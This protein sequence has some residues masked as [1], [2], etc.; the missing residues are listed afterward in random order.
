MLFFPHLA[1]AQYK[2][3]DF[4]LKSLDTT[5]SFKK[6]VEKTSQEVE[7]PLEINERISG[8]SISGSLKLGNNEDSYLRILMRDYNDND[9]LVY[10]CYPLLLNSK[11]AL[12]DNIGIETIELMNVRPKSL[13]VELNNSSLQIEYIHYQKE[14]MNKEQIAISREKLRKRQCDYIASMLN[15]HLKERGMTW[16]AGATSISLSTFEEKKDMFGGKVPQMYGFEYYI[17]G[18]FVMPNNNEEAK[19]IK[20]N[21]QY[22]DEWD[23]RNRHGKNWMTSVKRQQPCATCWAF[24]ALG[25]LEAYTNLYYNRLYN[26]DLSEQELLACM[27]NTCHSGGNTGAALSYV[28][29]NG[30]VEEECFPYSGSDND[31][32]SNKCQ[33]PSEKIWISNHYS[34]SNSL[35]ENAIKKRLLKAPLAFGISPWWHAIVLAGYKTIALGERIYIKTSSQDEWVTAD[36]SL[37]G[38]TAWLIKNSWG[39]TWGDNGYAY[40]VTNQSDLYLMY[41]LSGNITSMIHSDSDVLCED[42][43]GD[44]YYFWG[45][46]D[47]PSHC[48]SWVPDEPDGDD[49]DI[50]YGP[51][52]EYGN[53]EQLTCG[54]TINNLTTYTGNQTLSCR[55][56]IVNGGVLTIT[57]ST[58]MSGNAKIRVCEGGTLIVDGGIIQCAKLI[59]V[60]G[61]TIILKNGGIIN[62]ADG[63]TFEVPFGTIVNIVSGVIN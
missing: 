22:V 26:Y 46:G 51:M 1:T 14:L 11:T 49:S 50:N 38:K 55:I 32:C 27:N 52:D 2:T 40:V 29:N 18:I 56:G 42:A 53:L 45:I 54:Y 57:G 21:S 58:T 43:D 61:S 19:S 5:V 31:S 20:S 8:L 9:Y 35:G 59:L 63:E 48:P 33:S 10:E 23:W 12:F 62:M 24:T 6:V 36:S 47:K 41:Y 39:D 4:S 16:R 17:G 7:L 44:G 15:N 30:I 37:V 25:T 60:P 13:I 3:S 34:I 28:E